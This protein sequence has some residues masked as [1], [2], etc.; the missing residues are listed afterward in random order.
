MT[1]PDFKYTKK[2]VRF[3]TLFFII[4]L[5]FC[6]LLHVCAKSVIIDWFIVD[7]KQAAF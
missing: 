3:R 7:E 4:F 2:R 5:Y 6:F 1:F